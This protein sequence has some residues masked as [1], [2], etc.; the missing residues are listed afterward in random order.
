MVNVT[1][2]IYIAYMDPM[3]YIAIACYSYIDAGIPTIL[4][5]AAA[6]ETGFELNPLTDLVSHHDAMGLKM[7]PKVPSRFAK[8][9]EIFGSLGRF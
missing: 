4:A 6:V 7:S 2:Y 9:W 1:I 8:K 5:I 3:G